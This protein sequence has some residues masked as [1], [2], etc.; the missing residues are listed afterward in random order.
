MLP[1]VGTTA[2]ASPDSVL[3]RR[4]TTFARRMLI[5]DLPPSV[6]GSVDGERA[7]T[8]ARP[9]QRSGAARTAAECLARWLHCMQPQLCSFVGLYLCLVRGMRR[10]RTRSLIG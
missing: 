3:P 6:G 2:R 4:C 8:L 9:K 10:G 5:R 1:G 7:N